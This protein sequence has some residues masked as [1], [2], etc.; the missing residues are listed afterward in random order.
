MLI[1][2]YV[3]VNNPADIMDRYTHI[4]IWRSTTGIN[5]TYTEITTIATRIKL[6]VG[7]TTY[8]YY[9]E[10]GE[11]TY[12]YK[13]EYYNNVTGA[14]SQ[15]SDPQLGDD[16]EVL[17]GIM[18]VEELKNV[19]LVGVDLTDDS[20][21]PFPDIMYEFGIRAAIAWAEHVLDLDLRPTT[22]TERY[23]YDQQQ[24]QNAWGYIQLDRYPCLAWDSTVHSVKMYWPSSDE[25]Y[26]FP[27][28]WVRLERGSG[29]I[30]LI[31]TSGSIGSALMVSGAI[32]PTVLSRYPYLPRTIEVVYGS[33]FEAGAVPYDIRHIIGMKACFPIFNTAGDLVAGAGIAS[34][35][36]GVDGLSQSINTTSS[37]TN[38]GY[39]ARIL[40]YEREIK[41][42]IPVIKRYYKNVGLAVG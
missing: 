32:L 3:V 28:D 40:Q 22:N 38:S 19:F 16:S 18:T 13:S 4:R 6:V 20:G 29:Q 7:V 15:Q 27:N 17:A 8:T 9:D 31:P 1:K 35:S 37:S 30:N 36:L 10:N 34:Y 12:W 33:G 2:L 5:G 42:Q 26:T 24:F 41:Q 14:T 21:A 39:G 25:A 11:T 23:P